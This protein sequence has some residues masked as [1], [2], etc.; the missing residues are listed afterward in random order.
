MKSSVVL[1]NPP[2]SL[3]ERYGEDMKNFG[4]VSEPLG[5]AYIAAYLESRQG[6]LDTIAFAKKLNPLWAQFTITI[7]YPG[8][9]MFDE[10]DQK[11]QIRTYDWSRY[12][13]WSG[14]KG[15]KD[16]PFVAEGRT[17]EELSELQKKALRA[18]YMRPTVIFRF[19]IS[20][21]SFNDIKKY[22]AGFTTLV[23]SIGR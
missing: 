20:I 14:W 1:V 15:E 22:F 8:T 23:K 10:L 6:S 17:I 9:A 12:N 7:P 18:F 2:F 21:T 19:L 4:A 5:I 3:R 16:I 13:T 11:G